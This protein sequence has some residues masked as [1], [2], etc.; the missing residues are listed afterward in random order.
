MIGDIVIIG[1]RHY[2]KT[3]GDGTLEKLPDVKWFR[4]LQI[5][6]MNYWKKKT[7]GEVRSFYSRYRRR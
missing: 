2:V 5:F 4:S 6:F 7:I 1:N 3:N